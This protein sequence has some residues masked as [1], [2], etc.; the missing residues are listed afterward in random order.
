[1]FFVARK[2]DIE[3]ISLDTSDHTIMASERKRSGG[4]S[5]DSTAFLSWEFLGISLSR[6]I[7]T[8]LLME[9]TRCFSGQ[10]ELQ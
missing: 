4:I 8:V 3:A 7:H 2:V 6:L 5:P 9:M 1:M 10:P